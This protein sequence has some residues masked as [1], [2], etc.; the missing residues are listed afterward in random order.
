MEEKFSVQLCPKLRGLQKATR[1]TKAP[2]I[3]HCN[4]ITCQNIKP[5]QKRDKYKQFPSTSSSTSTL[6][7]LKHRDIRSSQVSPKVYVVPNLIL[8]FL[9]LLMTL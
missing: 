1:T 7:D 9:G 5:L 8:S 2:H 4:N 6:Q 3:I